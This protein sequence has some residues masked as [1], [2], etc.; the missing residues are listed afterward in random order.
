MTRGRSWLSCWLSCWL[1]VLD[2]LDHF[3]FGIRRNWLFS[4]RMPFLER[5]CHRFPRY[6]ERGVFSYKS[7]KVDSKKNL[8]QTTAASAIPALLCFR[9]EV[10]V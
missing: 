3:M 8:F 2:F 9:L 10:G 4:R 5:D 7:T 6:I 1:S